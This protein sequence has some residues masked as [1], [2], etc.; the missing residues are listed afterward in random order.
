VTDEEIIA[1]FDRSTTIAVVGAS[2]NPDKPSNAIPG[3]LLDAGFTMI[4]VN[5]TATEIQGQKVYANLE[6]VPVHVDIVDVF[7]PSGE[8]AGIAESATRIGA[9]TLWL[10]QGITSEEA[11]EAAEGAGLDYVEDLCIGATVKR[12]RYSKQ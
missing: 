8:A 12:L 6:D 1:L 11:K 5:P 9:D 4:P 2:E 10:Q 7:R 3:I